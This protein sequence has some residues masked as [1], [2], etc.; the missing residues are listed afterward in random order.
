MDEMAPVE[1]GPNRRFVFIAIGLVALL[2]LGLVGI[3][4]YI[5]FSRMRGR[6]VAPTPPAIAAVTIT[7]TPTMTPEVTATYT[8]V[9]TFTPVIRTPTPT[10]TVVGPEPT[11]PPTATATPTVTPAPTPTV[12]EGLPEGGFG[13]PALLG[14]VGLAVLLI[15]ARKVR[16]SS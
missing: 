1:E 6:A 10:P 4:G 2:L 15:V 14:G 8:P 5:L 3:F 11:V 12:E 7:P 16:L 9:P 13:L